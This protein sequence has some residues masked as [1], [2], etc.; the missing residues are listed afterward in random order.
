PDGHERF[1]TWINALGS[2]NPD[3]LA[4]EQQRQQPWGIGGRTNHY[5]IDL[6][7]DGIAMSQAESQQLAA[8]FLRWRPQVFVDHHGQ[9]SSYF[10]APPATPINRVLPAADIRKWT[11]IFGHANARSEEHTSELQSR[12]DLVCRL[13]LEKK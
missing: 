7:R 6:N 11:E 12:V 10:F 3:P 2:G 13:L 8:A 1:V 5:Q 4:L 9:T